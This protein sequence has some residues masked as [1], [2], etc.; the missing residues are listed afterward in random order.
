MASH[1]VLSRHVMVC[2]RRR[3][4][5]L[6]KPVA[7]TV[8]C[9]S[10]TAARHCAGD[11]RLLGNP[12]WRVHLR[13]LLIWTA[14]LAALVLSLVWSAVTG[15]S[16]AWTIGAVGYLGIV[17]VRA[18]ATSR[19]GYELGVDLSTLLVLTSRLALTRCCA[20]YHGQRIFSYMHIG[21]RVG[22]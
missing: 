15:F 7:C 22:C 21:R 5:C 4:A 13:G 3:Q 11:W 14:L 17:G 18:L 12:L 19:P 1:R 9:Q 6:S 16:L 8:E 20:T 10:D 2:M